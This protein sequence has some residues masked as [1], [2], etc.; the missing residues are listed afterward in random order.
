[1]RLVSGLDSIE[2]QLTRQKANDRKWTSRHYFEAT[3][4][5]E[6]EESMPNDY[7]L[8]GAFIQ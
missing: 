7:A 4:E 1:M 6:Q 3:T 5:E 8:N 2:H